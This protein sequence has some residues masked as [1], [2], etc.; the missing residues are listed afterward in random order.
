MGSPRR[1]ARKVAS[2][3]VVDLRKGG[4]LEGFTA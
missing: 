3:P 2:V 1:Q 4:F